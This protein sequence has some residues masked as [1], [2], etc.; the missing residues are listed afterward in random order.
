[1]IGLL[2]HKFYNKSFEE[3]TTHTL[4]IPRRLHQRG[5]VTV[6]NL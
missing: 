2:K 1:M 4:D 5:D 3:K 6:Q